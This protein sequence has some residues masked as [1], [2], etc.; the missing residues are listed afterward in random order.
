M[1]YP[2][3]LL[4]KGLE[5]IDT[6]GIGS[7]VQHNTHTARAVLPECDAVLVVLS[8]DPPITEVEVEFLRTVKDRVERVLF[9]L[10]KADLLTQPDRRDTLTFLQQVLRDQAGFSHQE[11]IFLVSAR[12]ALEARAADEPVP[13]APSGMRAL[14]A[15]LAGFLQTDK[16]AALQGAIQAKAAHLLGEA[17]FAVDLQRKAIDLPRQELERR[18]ER[19]EA[20]LAT[21]DSERLRVGDG[22]A[23]DGTRIAYHL[24]QHV[25]ALA[26]QAR[27]ALAAR[28]QKAHEAIAQGTSPRWVDHQVRAAIS[29]EMDRVCTQAAR[30]LLAEAAAHFKSMEEAHCRAVEVL[31][32]RIRRTAA[33]IFEVPC[34]EQVRLDGID[35]IREPHVVSRREITSFLEEAIAW[36]IRWLPPRWQAT[37]LEQR[38]RED[39]DY[40]VTCNM[41]E[42]RWATQQNL[43]DAIR[44]F[45]VRMETQ[46]SETITAVRTSI[47]AAVERQQ[48]REAAHEPACQRVDAHRQRVMELLAILSPSTSRVLPGGPV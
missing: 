21:I 1:E 7:T 23:G 9:V 18:V 27:A 11:R 28:A 31:L 8:P 33:D 15:Y 41:G 26:P 47:R 40:L 24:A 32:A 36:T 2:S 22:L 14:E 19:F 45:Q 43:Q 6:P 42:L 37:Y 46:L 48:R 30:S 35:V 39:I 38:L 12:R 3:P 29:E 13:E 44:A 5:I 20:Q 4:A 34:L 16:H 10:T 17:V 25:E